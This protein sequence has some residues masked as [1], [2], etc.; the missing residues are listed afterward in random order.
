MKVHPQPE[1]ESIFRTVFAWWLRFGGI[2]RRSLRERRLK[3][4]RQ[5]FWG[6]SAPQT[7]SWLRLWNNEASHIE[8]LP[9]QHVQWRH[10]WLKCYGTQGNAVP[11]P[12]IYDSKRS[13]TSDC[14]NARER[15]TTI[16]GGPNLNVAF[17]HL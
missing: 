13:P 5:L 4:G 8:Q 10:Q 3:K 16:V 6:K 14:Y 11:P 17:P 1:Q 2:F 9:Y 12:P 7:K 15:H